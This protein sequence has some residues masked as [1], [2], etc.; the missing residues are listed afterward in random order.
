MLSTLRMLKAAIINKEK[1]K[2]EELGEE[3]IISVIQSEAKKR[4][5]AIA[6]FQK[7]NR[8]DLV[9]KEEAELALLQKYLPTELPEQE[10]V[11]IIKNVIQEVEAVG[12]QDMGRVMKS[13]M[14]KVKGRADGAK[15]SALVKKAL[16]K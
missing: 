14:E 13:V 10:L 11:D 12:R 2:K 3:E 4:K 9:E 15:V 5:D 6:Q 1:D 7:A 16:T 8:Q